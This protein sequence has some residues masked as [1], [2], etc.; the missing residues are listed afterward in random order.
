MTIVFTKQG[1]NAFSLEMDQEE[2]V[3][4]G[5]N[6]STGTFKTDSNQHDAL[7]PPTAH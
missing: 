2:I 5:M 1:L 4:A 3:F 7:V 6:I